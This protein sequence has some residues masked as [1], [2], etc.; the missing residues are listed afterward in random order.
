MNCFAAARRK[1]TKGITY[2]DEWIV[3]CLLMRMRSPRLYEH[4]RREDIL[5]GRTCLQRYLRRFKGGFGMNPKIFSALSEKTKD[6]DTFSCRGGIVL[7]EIKL[8]EHRNVKSSGD[9]EGFVDLGDHT[10]ADQKGVLTDHGMVVMFQPFTV[11]LMAFFNLA[12]SPKGGNC[13]QEVVKELLS[14]TD[15]SDASSSS[16]FD[17]LDGLF[18]QGKVDDVDEAIQAASEGAR[19]RETRLG[20]ARSLRLSPSGGRRWKASFSVP[21]GRPRSAHYKKNLQQIEGAKH[22]GFSKQQNYLHYKGSCKQAP[23]ALTAP[24]ANAHYTASGG[25][26]APQ[27]RAET[28]SRDIGGVT[29]M[30]GA[31]RRHMEEVPRCTSCIQCSRKLGSVLTGVSLC[32]TA[33][34]PRVSPAPATARRINQLICILIFRFPR[35]ALRPSSSSAAAL[36]GFSE[37]FATWEQHAGGGAGGFLSKSTASGLRV[38][39]SSTLEFLSYLQNLR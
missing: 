24:C 27:R 18:E 37:Y 26:A 9:I 12:K 6:M 35:G 22:C 5:P 1:S 15:A 36:S 20:I 14:P 31:G 23:M 10:S 25:G 16:L 11:N 33:L 4:L 38:I 28:T 34:A 29:A 8:S 13:S 19:W 17:A 32:H 7:D 3:E 2:E 21:P 30:H 39:V